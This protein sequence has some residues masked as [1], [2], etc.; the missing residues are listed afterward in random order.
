[1]RQLPAVCAAMDESNAA[2]DHLLRA[3]RS[4]ADF[5]DR[6]RPIQADRRRHFSVIVEGHGRP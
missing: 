3:V 1:M 6:E 5:S 2:E 4:C